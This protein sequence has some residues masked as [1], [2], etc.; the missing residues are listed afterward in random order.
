MENG[1]AC[2]KEFQNA[3]VVWPDSVRPDASV[4]VPEIMT[5]TLTAMLLEMLFDREQRGLGVERVEDGLDHQQI[6]AAIQQAADGLA[7]TLH[8]LIETDVA[9][10][11]IVHVRRDRSGTRGRSQHAGDEARLVRNL[12]LEFIAHPARQ[13]RA[14][15][16]QFIGQV[17]HAVIGQRHGGGIECAGL[18]DVRARRQIFGVDAADDVRL[19]QQQQVVV[20]FDIDRMVGKGPARDVVV[21]KTLWIFTVQHRAPIVFL[22]QF[23]A[24]DHRAHRTVQDQDALPDELF[25]R[26]GN[27]GHGVPRK[28]RTRIL[29][30]RHASGGRVRASE[31]QPAVLHR[32]GDMFRGDGVCPFQVGDAARHFEYAVIG[33]RRQVEAAD[34]LL[35]HR[36]ALLVR[37]A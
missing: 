37:R 34:G 7:I 29:P 24:L 25:D 20:A 35:Q 9:R 32:L 11:G 18:D 12:R 16:I 2:D 13:F 6:R 30:C 33:A 5:G 36:A 31:I 26:V 21:C 3:S 22:G 8:Q 28:K 10:A 15:Q 4:I 19:G 23:V 1:R 27:A 17:C 14:G